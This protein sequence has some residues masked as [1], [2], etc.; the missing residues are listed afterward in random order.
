MGVDVEVMVKCVITPPG[1]ET[2]AREAALGVLSAVASRA[3]AQVLHPLL[4]VCTNLEA[5]A[6]AASHRA[7]NQ[8]RTQF[9]L[10]LSWSRC[11]LSIVRML[12]AQMIVWCN[13]LICYCWLLLMRLCHLCGC[14]H[15][16]G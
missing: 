1:E 10:L 5:E 4:T 16:C 15:L 12:C 2:Q 8:V 7:L 9:P 6:L 14:C 13:T 11:A 3:P